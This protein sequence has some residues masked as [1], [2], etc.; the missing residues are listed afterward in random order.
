M[1][2]RMFQSFM[3]IA[4]RVGPALLD[5]RPVGAVDRLLYGLGNLLV[6]GPLKNTLGMSRVRVAYTAGE[7]VGPEIFN[8][9]RALGVNMKQ[10]YGQTEAG[11]RHQPSQRRGRRHGHKPVPGSSSGSPELEVVTAAR[12]VQEYFEPEA[13]NDAKTEDGW[14]TPATRLP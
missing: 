11:V 5:G 8:F 4:R 12:R 1:K 14:C 2:R 3:A 13:T 6:Y 7:A 10:L 9:Y